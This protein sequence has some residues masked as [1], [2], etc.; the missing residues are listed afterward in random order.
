MDVIIRTLVVASL[1]APLFAASVATL[2]PPSSQQAS[3][4]GVE[5]FIPLASGVEGDQPV[6]VVTAL[7]GS[8]A[9]VAL[10]DT[11]SLEFY[12]TSSG[13]RLGALRVPATPVDLDTTPDGT[14]VFVACQDAARIVVVHVATRTLTASIVVDPGPFQVEALSDGFRAVVACD[15][16]GSGGSL[17][18]IDRILGTATITSPTVSLAPLVRSS[19][20][21]AGVSLDQ[22][23]EIAV[24][25]D[26]RYIVVPGAGC[27]CIEVHDVATLTLVASFTGLSTNPY[28]AAAAPDSSYVAVGSGSVLGLGSN[29]LY[30]VDLP[31]LAL[32]E[33]PINPSSSHSDVAVTPNSAAVLYGA[34]T[35]VMR[36][37]AATGQVNGIASTFADYGEI[38]ISSTGNFAIV[39]AP[40]V[41][42]IDIATMTPFSLV[43][44]E[45]RARLAML[46]GV[47]AAV[48]IFPYVNESITR[49]TIAPFISTV[50]WSTEL[51][52]PVELDAPYDVALT[53]DERRAVVTC[54]TSG[55][56]AIVDTSTGAISAIVDLAAASFDVD[57]SPTGDIAL[58]ALLEERE[59][60]SVDLTTTQVVSRL[61]L[62]GQ[63]SSVFF[64]PDGVRAVV[65]S[66]DFSTNTVTTLDVSGGVLTPTGS[67]VQ[68]G[69]F[70][71][72]AHLSPDGTR[73]AGIE[74]GSVTIVDVDSLAL[75]THVP[76]P[77]I[78]QYGYWS[79]D[80]SR[81]GWSAN[82]IESRVVALG[83]ATGP[84][85]DVYSAPSIV[86]K[87]A[88]G[89]NGAYL[90]Q[91]LIDDHIRVVDLASGAE[92][93]LVTLPNSPATQLQTMPRWMEV[94]GGQLLALRTES[95][96][97]LYRL[98]MAGP[99]TTLLET[100]PFTTEG[101]S[102]VAFSHLTGRVFL[103]AST[104]G[105]GL[106][107]VDY[108]GSWSSY[109][110]PAVPNSTGAS[111]S[112]TA[113]GPFLAGDVPVEL[114][115]TNVPPFS[116]GMF[117]A[118][119]TPGSTLPSTSQ[120]RLCLGGAIGRF[121]ASI[122]SAGAIGNLTYDV[123]PTGL[124]F[125]TGG[126]ALPGDSIYFQ[127]WFRDANPMTT[128]NFSN[129][130]RVNFR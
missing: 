65:V 19:S 1:A 123:D 88:F 107:V 69:A 100:V 114:T 51:G 28:R 23:V 116:F 74:F 108:G 7:A 80:S 31:S 93:A 99:A 71:T 102:N 57:V 52:V 2:V 81:F 90:Y 120:G 67:W 41:A 18:V 25:P 26:D 95:V 9:V 118:S 13:V 85:V 70:W 109:C 50:A 11:N 35:S 97:A 101:T 20:P 83:G 121:V 5:P 30:L 47:D 77:Y 115:A 46:P 49:F 58:V 75:V 8:V 96:A 79:A 53:M 10:R 43:P 126:T 34:T 125:A 89:P 39:T 42:V 15:V 48:A 105:D 122:Q 104:S 45:S 56:L 17:S 86:T 124:P 61:A 92:V 36:I 72:E 21:L 103:P 44:A 112:I 78:T 38:E 40:G 106:R 59:V 64:R 4:L 128:S 98:S 119:R 62:G 24:T 117:L 14:L 27:Q 76:S 54:P 94:V 129:G 63:V 82:I 127:A 84:V 91:F 12:D 110:D 55:N 113:R 111:A 87:A 130:A 6:D 60:V 73:L 32:R 16:P 29:R 68:P 37:D 33:I 22:R 66:T 3:T